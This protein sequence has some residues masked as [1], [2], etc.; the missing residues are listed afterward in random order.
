MQYDLLVHNIG[1]LILPQESSKPLKGE[2][3]KQLTVKQNA[4][5]AIRAGQIAWIGTNEDANNIQTKESLDAGQKVVSPGLVDPHTHLVFGGSREKE[6]VL[7]QAG[8][9]YLEILAKGGGILSTVEAT[10]KATENELYEKASFHLKRIISYGVTM[11]EAKSG[12]GLDPEAELKQLKVVKKLQDN[13]PISIVST[14]LGPHAIPP[15]YKG[16]ED[17]FLEEMVQLLDTVKE[18][19]LAE[20]ADIFCETGVFTTQQSKYFLQKAKEKGFGLKIHADEIDSLGG[21]ELAVKLGATSA[22]HLVAA[23]DEAIDFLCK[24]ETVAVLLPGTTF[25][26][27]KDTYA[28]ARKM[29]DSGAAV[30]LATDFNPGSCVTENLQ[31]I[32]S[33]AALKLKM[34]PEEIWNAVTVNAAFA[35]GR[36]GEAGTLTIGQKANFV[37][38]DIPNYMYLPYHFGVNHTNSVYMNGTKVWGRT[39]ND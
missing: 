31:L 21:T 30:A 25:Y 28:R 6:L 18:D 27:G 17:E 2:E 34:T 12:Y 3:M 20:F 14:F 33:L 11:M 16:K 24:G 13:Y 9:P 15:S 35:I 7:K 32:M 26:L 19:K 5:F 38:W 8:V 37:L 10:R 4:A 29:I 36:G 1:Q 22:D 39:D 23:S